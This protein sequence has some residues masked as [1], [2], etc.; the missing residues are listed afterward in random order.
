MLTSII[1]FFIGGFWIGSQEGYNEIVQNSKVS[2]IFQRTLALVIVSCII[3][4]L[5]YLIGRV[6]YKLDRMTVNKVILIDFIVLMFLS[7]SIVFYHHG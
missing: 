3:L 6:I 4:V 5:I 7:I 1:L 2:F